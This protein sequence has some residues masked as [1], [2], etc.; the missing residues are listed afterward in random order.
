MALGLVHQSPA[1]VVFLL[2]VS[3]PRTVLTCHH[4]HTPYGVLFD[5]EFWCFI[6]III[7]IYRENLTFFCGQV[8]GPFPL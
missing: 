1:V 4:I 5:F 8:H 6:I 3:L 2:S 7:I